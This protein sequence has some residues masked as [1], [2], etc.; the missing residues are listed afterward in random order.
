M[1]KSALRIQREKRGWSLAHVAEKIGVSNAQVH[2]IEN[3]GVRSA[4][5]ARAIAELFDGGITLD[6]ICIGPT[7]DAA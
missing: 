6:Q 7:E 5:T 1:S 3:H 2:R 4:E